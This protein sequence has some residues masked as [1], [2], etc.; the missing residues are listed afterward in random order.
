MKKPVRSQQRAGVAGRA[1]VCSLLADL[2]AARYGA[3]RDGAVV[4]IRSRGDE[5]PTAAFLK[6]AN[7]RA[8]G[9]HDGNHGRSAY[10]LDVF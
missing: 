5:E 6:V 3:Q 2:F 8:V 9:D 4:R 1:T 7:V 10:L